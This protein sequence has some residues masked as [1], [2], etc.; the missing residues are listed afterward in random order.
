MADVKSTTSN[1]YEMFT[2]PAWRALFSRYR[3]D[4]DESWTGRGGYGM[5]GVLVCKSD[6]PRDEKKVA[7]FRDDGDGAGTDVDCHGTERDYDEFIEAVKTLPADDFVG[8]V[9]GIDAEIAIGALAQVAEYK[10]LARGARGKARFMFITPS[11]ADETV[12]HIDL[13]KDASIATARSTIMRDHPDAFLLNEL[14]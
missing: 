9:I 4:I 6:L 13:P 14:F 2:H 8:I 1:R 10:R 5:T 3:V 7:V 11:M 12:G